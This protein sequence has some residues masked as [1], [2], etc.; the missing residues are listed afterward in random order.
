MDGRSDSDIIRL[1]D[2]TP[3]FVFREFLAIKAIHILSPEKADAMH[4]I[5]S[6]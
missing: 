5:G 4:C 6:Q 3:Q 1:L 2:G